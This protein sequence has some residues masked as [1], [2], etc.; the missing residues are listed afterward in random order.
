M[1]RIHP[2]PLRSA[3]GINIRA[4][5]GFQNHDD[6]SQAFSLEAKDG[7]ITEERQR[8]RAE[9]FLNIPHVGRARG[10]KRGH[11]PSRKPLTG[12]G[13]LRLENRRPRC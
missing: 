8:R 7:I 10:Q 5:E 6:I 11:T 12:L 2:E 1:I 4:V 3:H 13:A 9:D